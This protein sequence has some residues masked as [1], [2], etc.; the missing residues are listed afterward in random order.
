M[1][2]AKPEDL[3]PMVIVETRTD[4]PLSETSP[5]VTRISGE[6][7]DRRQIYNLADALRSVP[8]MAIAR[9]GQLGSQTSLF[10]RGGESNHVT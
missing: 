7:L 2:T 8:G 1:A 4:Q 9:T 5:W 3:E 10:S 6:D